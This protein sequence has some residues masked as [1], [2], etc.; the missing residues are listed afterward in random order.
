MLLGILLKKIKGDK[1]ISGVK[2]YEWVRKW[3]YLY[4]KIKV[5]DY[6]WIIKWK[7]KLIIINKL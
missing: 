5:N 4:I 7:E 1:I 6:L 2:I 3:F